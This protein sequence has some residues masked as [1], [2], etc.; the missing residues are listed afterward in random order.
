M[1]GSGDGIYARRAL[2]DGDEIE[3]AADIVNTGRKGRRRPGMGT[4][5][6]YTLSQYTPCGA[7]APARNVPE[8]CAHSRKCI[9]FNP[10][11]LAS[12]LCCAPIF[13]DSSVDPF[14]AAIDMDR[15]DLNKMHSCARYTECLKCPGCNGGVYKGVYMLR[16]MRRASRQLTG[17]AWIGGI[18][19]KQ[20]CDLVNAEYRLIRINYYGLKGCFWRHARKKEE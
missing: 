9:D 12:Y 20:M 5:T 17:L 18:G 7:A 16:I 10:P 11:P 19:M 1:T 2:C 14:S 6:Q 4:V 3:R 8:W 15:P 13:C